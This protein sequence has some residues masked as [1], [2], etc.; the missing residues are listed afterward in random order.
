M[1][2][3]RHEEPHSLGPLPTEASRGGKSGPLCGAKINLYC[4]QQHR[5]LTEA[6]LAKPSKEGRPGEGREA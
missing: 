2:T 5:G 4:F 3:D 1:G 6:A